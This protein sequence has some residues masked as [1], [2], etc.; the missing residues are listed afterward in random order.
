MVYYKES[1]IMEFYT[2][3]DFLQSFFIAAT[4]NSIS[5]RQKGDKIIASLL[6]VPAS[7]QSFWRDIFFNDESGEF[8]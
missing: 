3:V 7:K 5:G 4:N 8:Y 6:G 2:A 1:F